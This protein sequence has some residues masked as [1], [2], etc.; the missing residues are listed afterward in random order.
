MFGA[1]CSYSHMLM[2]ALM[3]ASRTRQKYNYYLSECQ[4]LSY[5]IVLPVGKVLKPR[6]VVHLWL[7]HAQLLHKFMYL[8][9]PQ[10]LSGRWQD[11]RL[12]LRCSSR[13]LRTTLTEESWPTIPVTMALQQSKTTTDNVGLT[14]RL[15]WW[16]PWVQGSILQRNWAGLMPTNSSSLA[17]TGSMPQTPSE[18]G[19]VISFHFCPMRWE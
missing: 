6:S 16:Y 2:G 3:A 7:F 19:H 1:T 12:L 15:P 9:L 4:R 18:R 11:T 14:Y 5:P 17:S 13:N 8:Q 10:S